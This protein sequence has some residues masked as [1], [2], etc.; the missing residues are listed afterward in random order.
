MCAVT[1]SGLAAKPQI[2]CTSVCG[3]VLPEHL[4][5]N[6]DDDAKFSALPSIYEN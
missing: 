2:D 1:E 3:C 5:N 6:E 4:C